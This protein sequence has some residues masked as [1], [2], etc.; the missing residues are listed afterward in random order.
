MTFDNLLGY[1]LSISMC[2]QS[3]ITIV[4][5][6]RPFSL[7]QNLEHGTASTDVKC[8]FAISWA[9]FG[10]PSVYT[11]VYQYIPHSSRDKAIFTFSEF[12]ARQSLDHDKCHFAIVSLFFSEFE[13]R[14]KLNQSQMSFDN[15]MGYILSISMCM[16]NFIIIFHSLQEIAPLSLFRIWSSAKPRPM[17][18]I[19]SQSLGLDLVNINVYATVYQNIPLSLRD[20]P[21]SLFQ[22]LA[23]GKA[24]IDDK[25]HFAIP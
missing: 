11:E 1:I 5:S 10:N 12:G 19:I 23:L 9:R 14:Q 17:K 13:P 18:N 24:S 7:F 16:Q 3:F 6:V 22:N 2:M 21:F 8:H 4:H 20:G 15:L 25:C